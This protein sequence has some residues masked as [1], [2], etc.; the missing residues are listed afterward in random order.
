MGVRKLLFCLSILL[1]IIQ[2]SNVSVS[3]E[4]LRCSLY[5]MDEPVE[6]GALCLYLDFSREEGI[7]GADIEIAHD[8]RLKLTK[9][10]MA[11]IQTDDVF[12]YVDKN[13][14]FKMVFS[15]ASD[16]LT[17]GTIKL[18]FKSEG[19]KSGDKLVFT[20]NK[21]DFCSDSI[22]MIVPLSF[23]SA[24]ITVSKSKTESK[25]SKTNT[26]KESEASVSD[27]FTES[28]T[29]ISEEIYETNDKTIAESKQAPVYI[30]S[31]GA[32]DTHNDRSMLLYIA[33][34]AAV[35]SIAVFLAYRAGK[36][37]QK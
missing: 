17:S 31:E 24:E 34:T 32:Q 37:K 4:D 5:F 21:C 35:V 10:E 1:L 25:T 29:E 33:V 23:P 8:P 6:G 15:I 28:D 16:K 27:S 2:A 11:D 14:L 12:E 22:E 7:Y 36:R 26:K 13:G 20:V 30:V 19:V 9:A 18:R 3:A